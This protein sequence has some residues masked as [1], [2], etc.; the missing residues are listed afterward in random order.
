M[1][2]LNTHTCIFFYLASLFFRTK[3]SLPLPESIRQLGANNKTSNKDDP[4]KHG[5][6]IRSFPHEE[7]NWA[8]LVYIP[9]KLI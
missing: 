9:C 7:G 2:T 4:L 8:T 3:P 6:R 1:V 5:G